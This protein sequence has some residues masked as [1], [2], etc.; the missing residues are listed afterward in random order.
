MEKSCVVRFLLGCVR[1]FVLYIVRILKP[2]KILVSK[3]EQLLVKAVGDRGASARVVLN[4][5]ALWRCSRTH[6]GDQ[7]GSRKPR[8]KCTPGSG[9]GRGA[10]VGRAEDQRTRI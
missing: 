9:W 2:P 8:R 7:E 4:T 3:M 6:V 10:Q 5:V 1:M